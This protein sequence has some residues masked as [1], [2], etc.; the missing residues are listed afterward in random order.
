MLETCDLTV[1]APTNRSSA[2]S[3]LLDPAETATRT[4]RS[5]P[6]SSSK[7]LVWARRGRLALGFGLLLVSRLAGMVLPA[8]TKILIDEVIGNERADLLVWIALAAGVATLI[9][10]GTSFALTVIL[11]VAGQ[12]AITDLRRQVQAG[13]GIEKGFRFVFL[14]T[15]VFQAQ[16]VHL[17]ATTEAGDGQGGICAGGD[18]HV[19]LRGKIL[20]QVTTEIVNGLAPSAGM[21][22]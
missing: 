4:S 15:Q 14:K 18:V 1:A 13:Q 9:Q 7:R 3:M 5:R 12:R 19:R 21:K 16:F 8:S 10:A 11:G 2:I 6:V 22:V 20:N 17:A